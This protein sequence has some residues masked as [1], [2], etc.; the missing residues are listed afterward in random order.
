LTKQII[1]HSGFVVEFAQAYNNEKEIAG[2]K[3]LLNVD[4]DNVDYLNRE[5]IVVG[6]PHDYSGDVKIG[7]T[8]IVHHNITRISTRNDGSEFN[9]YHIRQ[10]L[11]RVPED[12]VFLYRTNKNE[13]W[14]SY[15][16][17]IFVSPMV[18]KTE[19]KIGSILIPDSVQEKFVNNTGIVSI[20]NLAL[21]KIGVKKG[22]KIYFKNFSEHKYQ[23]DDQL[24]YK[25]NV[26]RVLG[27]INE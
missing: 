10:N 23:I 25:M 4:K 12:L 7:D 1:T 15:G 24:L 13:E 21:N 6:L 26:D 27:L 9:Q 20:E 3:L 16:D 19:K 11:Y 18:N 17:Y 5:C 22:D 14:K 8:L 2:V